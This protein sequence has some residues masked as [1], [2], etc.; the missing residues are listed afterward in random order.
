MEK[1]LY[2]GLD[3]HKASIS[4][5]RLKTDAKGQS[6]LLAPSRTRRQPY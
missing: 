6:I 5:S 3:V 2:V 1:I 4:V